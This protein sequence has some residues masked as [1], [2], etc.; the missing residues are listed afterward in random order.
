M[1]DN[2]SD[3]NAKQTAGANV[4]D[5]QNSTEQAQQTDTSTT[6][7]KDW[8]AEAE[9]WRALARKH[10]G[11]AKTN[12]SAAQELATIKDAQKTA[13]QRLNDQLAAAQVQLAEYRTRETRTN[14]ALAAGLPPEMAEYITEAEPDSALEQAKRLAEHL[15]PAAQKPAADLRQGV[16]GA[17]AQQAND[18]NAWLRRMAGRA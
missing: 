8:K 9:K 18:P 5:G 14:A 2:N 10:E 11:N 16:R 7:E 13:E 3:D 4:Q 15:K 6:D 17:P 1:D 12:A